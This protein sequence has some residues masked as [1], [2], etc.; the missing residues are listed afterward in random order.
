MAFQIISFKPVMTIQKL[1]KE[2][3]EVS[4]IAHLKWTIP[5]SVPNASK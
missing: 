2:N 1:G 5:P 4:K 3:V